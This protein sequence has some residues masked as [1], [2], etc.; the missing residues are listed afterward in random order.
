M[1]K[2]DLR[3]GFPLICLSN[4]LTLAGHFQRYPRIHDRLVQFEGFVFR[5]LDLKRVGPYLF[6]TTA[7]TPM[8]R[9]P[10]FSRNGPFRSIYREPDTM[11]ETG[12]EDIATHLHAGIVNVA[13]GTGEIQLSPLSPIKVAAH[14]VPSLHTWMRNVYSHRLAVEPLPVG[15]DQSSHFTALDVLNRLLTIGLQTGIDIPNQSAQVVRV[16]IVNRVGVGRCQVTIVE[17]LAIGKLCLICLLQ[18][19]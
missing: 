17:A 3:P 7:V 18:P 8:H 14:L 6:V 12:T 4:L 2:P 19:P 1:K 16:N 10:R 5:T 15:R 9:A 13:I 11:A